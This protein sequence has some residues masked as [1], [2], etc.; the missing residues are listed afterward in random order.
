MLLSWFWARLS[1]VSDGKLPIPPIDWSA[2]LL[3]F[4]L[5]KE[6]HSSME[7]T[8]VI[9]LP[10]KLSSVTS[11]A[12]SPHHSDTC[13][14]VSCIVKCR[15]GKVGIQIDRVKTENACSEKP[16]TIRLL[17][18]QHHPTCMIVIV[19]SCSNVIQWSFN[20]IVVHGCL[21][22]FDQKTWWVPFLDSGGLSSC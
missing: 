16:P 7:S 18:V 1:H 8:L 22:V 15:K 20:I 5:R 17:H 6:V 21:I 19:T 3:R 11:E 10:D 9:S 13:L 4:S 12:A 2:F 14:A